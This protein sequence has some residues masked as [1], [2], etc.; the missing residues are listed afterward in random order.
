MPPPSMTVFLLVG[1]F[2]VAVIAM[3][4]GA[5][6]Q[7]KVMTPPLATAVL[8]ALNVQLAAVPVPITE[9]GLETSAGWPVA[10]TP[11][12]HDPLG[13]PAVT[14]PLPPVPVGLLPPVPVVLRPPVPVGLLPPVLLPPVPVV[15]LPPV[16]VVLP[17][18]FEV[19]EP[20][21]HPTQRR[22][23]RTKANE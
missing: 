15:L 3:V 13:F 21:P 12:L 23:G 6:P 7:L 9:V 5:L 4:T 14:V 22:T 18:S 19:A 16:P 17:A 8:S 11:A 10:G 1:R 2:M 20:E